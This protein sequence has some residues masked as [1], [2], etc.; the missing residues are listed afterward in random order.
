[1]PEELNG[2]AA[3][4]PAT[5]PAYLEAEGIHQTPRSDT[6]ATADQVRTVVTSLTRGRLS[7][8]FAPRQARPTEP[9]DT[10]S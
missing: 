9:S 3:G 10:A 7:L 1:M 6:A 5:R 4:E 2:T 8:R